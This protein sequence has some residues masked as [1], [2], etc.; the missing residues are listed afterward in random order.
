MQIPINDG[1][2]VNHGWMLTGVS[3]GI[4]HNPVGCA[5]QPLQNY[6]SFS[7]PAGG[8]R[9]GDGGADGGGVPVPLIL[10]G[11]KSERFSSLPGRVPHSRFFC[12]LFFLPH[13]PSVCG[14]GGWQRFAVLSVSMEERKHLVCQ[15]W[16]NIF[17]FKGRQRRRTGNKREKY[18]LSVLCRQK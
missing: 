14:T 3:F 7:F 9:F 18:D 6:I 17:F 2:W 11:G 4:S 1:F 16:K 8:E 12:P 5:V 13:S 15:P 10:P